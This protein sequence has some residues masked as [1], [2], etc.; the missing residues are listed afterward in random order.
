MKYLSTNYLPDELR[1]IY[2]TYH[3]TLDLILSYLT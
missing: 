1:A 3:K 2:V